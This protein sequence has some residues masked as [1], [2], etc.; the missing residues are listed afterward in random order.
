MGLPVE[1]GYR[2]WEKQY[3]G[4]DNVHIEYLIV[5]VD[6]AGTS[7]VGTPIELTVYRPKAVL[8]TPLQA[9]LQVRY[10]AIPVVG[11][12]PADSTPIGVEVQG[13][14]IDYADKGPTLRLSMAV[15]ADRG[16]PGQPAET[17]ATFCLK[18]RSNHVIPGGLFGDDALSAA[19]DRPS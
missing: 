11:W 2:L 13:K 17:D 18:V 5:P 10:N 1:D 14:T 12:S 8:K 4:S 3:C 16:D 9:R 7:D 15:D 19:L 6:I